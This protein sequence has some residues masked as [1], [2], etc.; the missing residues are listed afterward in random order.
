MRAVHANC[1]EWPDL[2]MSSPDDGVLLWLGTGP[3]TWQTPDSPATTV[4]GPVYVLEDDI[5]AIGDVDGDGKLDLLA[6]NPPGSQVQWYSFAG[7]CDSLFW[8]LENACWGEFAEGGLSSDIF[9]NTSCFTSTGNAGTHNGLHAG[10]ALAIADFDNDGLQDLVLGDLNT[11][12]LVY[13]HNGGVPAFASMDGV[14]NNF[15]AGQPVNLR[16]FV[17]PFFLDLDLDGDLDLLAAPNDLAEGRNVNQLWRYENTSPGAMNLIRREED[18]LVGGMLDVGERANPAFADVNA[19]GQPDMIVG[20]AGFRE[21]NGQGRSGLFL[22][23]NTGTVG[24]PAFDL[25]ND[26]WLNLPALFNP[27]LSAIRPAFADVDQDGDEDMVLGD[28]EGQLHLFIN[29]AAPGAAA[30]FTLTSAN[31]LT[32]DVGEY[33]APAFGDLDGDGLLDLLIGNAAG[34]FTLLQNLSTAGNIT[35]SSPILQ[36]GGVDLSSCCGGH[37]V[38]ALWERTPKHW[39]L[40]VGTEHGQVLRYDSLSLVPGQPFVLVDSAFGLVSPVPGASPVGVS[41]HGGPQPLWFL[42]TRAGGVRI[43]EESSVNRVRQEAMAGYWRWEVG[44]GMLRVWRTSE[45]QPGEAICRLI[46]VQGQQIGQLSLNAGT[47]SGE[48]PLGDLSPGM[49]LLEI[50]GKEGRQTEKILWKE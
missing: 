38:P 11:N 2:L 48:M 42:G 19:D 9:L 15:P 49:Y 12:N 34:T 37:A 50:V 18:W 39:E 40:V 13:L 30:L 24:N 36:A 4:D 10:S 32:L 8:R 26:N 14:V 7:D 35:F 46:N 17:A 3:Y 31:W 41:L 44:D 6:F 1:D 29:T 22:Y 21:N 20:Q 47:L 27:P 5:P 28:R 23:L 43:F 25:L 45:G 33:A 16:R